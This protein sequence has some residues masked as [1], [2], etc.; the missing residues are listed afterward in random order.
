MGEQHLVKIRFRSNRQGFQGKW[1]S[2]YDGNLDTL[3]HVLQET[4]TSRNVPEATILEIEEHLCEMCLMKRDQVDPD[5]PS[6]K[7]GATGDGGDDAGK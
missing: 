1:V 3:H 4:I 6:V 2:E 7:D 5:D